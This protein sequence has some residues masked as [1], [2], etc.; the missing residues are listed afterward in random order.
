MMVLLFLRMLAPLM[1][2]LFGRSKELILVLKK[3]SP[4]SNPK[5]VGSLR[6]IFRKKRQKGLR[7]KE[8]G[9]L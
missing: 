5:K 7:L 3:M 1:Q 8:F 6:R 2:T 9:P 4:L